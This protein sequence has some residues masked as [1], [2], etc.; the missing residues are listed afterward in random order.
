MQQKGYN[1]YINV[2]WLTQRHNGWN[3]L[4]QFMLKA[5]KFSVS[6]TKKLLQTSVNKL[7]FLKII[8]NNEIHFSPLNAKQRLYGIATRLRTIIQRLLKQLPHF[9]MNRY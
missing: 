8:S 4:Y 9:D 3:R 6:Y 2:V 5:D 1:I 7:N